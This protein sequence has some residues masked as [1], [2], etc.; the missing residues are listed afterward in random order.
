MEA[1]QTSLLNDLQGSGLSL[2]FQGGAISLVVLTIL[3]AMSVISWAIICRK[4]PTFSAALKSARMFMR[5]VDLENGFSD[6]KY[7]S[8]L[9]PGTYTAVLFETAFQE[10]EKRKRRENYIENDESKHDFLLRIERK[11]ESSIVVQNTRNEKDLNILATISSSAPF[12]GLLGTV[13]GIIDAFYSIGS[14]GATSIAVVA[15]GIS[16]ALVATAF[17]LF[18]AIPA[19]IAY[20]VFRN[21]ARLINNEMRSFGLE[22]INLFD[23]EYAATGLRRKPAGL[24]IEHGK[25]SDEN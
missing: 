11:I 15:P 22:L 20:N 10:F 8:E 7:R 4:W 3:L 2:I 13:T 5:S 24:D 6:I 1:Q 12:I 16:S 9:Y 17:G 25:T 23:G 19:L 21:K 18:A 14:Q